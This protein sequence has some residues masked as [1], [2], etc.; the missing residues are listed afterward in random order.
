MNRQQQKHMDL[1]R[2]MA[3]LVKALIADVVFAQY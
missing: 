3:P 2:G 1:V